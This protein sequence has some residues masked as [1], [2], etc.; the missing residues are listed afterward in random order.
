[1]NLQKWMLKYFAKQLI[2][3]SNLPNGKNLL[4]IKLEHGLR[5]QEPKNIQYLEDKFNVK[6]KMKSS[7]SACMDIMQ[8]VIMD[9]MLLLNVHLFHGPKKIKMFKVV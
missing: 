9:L 6:K 8:D 2:H 4:L 5:K 7:A 3:N 1:M